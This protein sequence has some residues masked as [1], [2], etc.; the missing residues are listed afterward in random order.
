MK[1]MNFFIQSAEEQYFTF[2]EYVYDRIPEPETQE[3]EE[4][5]D[6]WISSLHYREF[7][8]NEAGKIITRAINIHFNK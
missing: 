7:S 1:L 4:A 2:M 6:K 8:M 3:Q 5:V